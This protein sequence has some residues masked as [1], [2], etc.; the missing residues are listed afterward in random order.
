V[1]APVSMSPL[2]S[3]VI[4]NYKRREAFARSL[5]SVRGQ[6]YPNRE[7]IVVD[8]NSQDGI[9]EYLAAHAPEVRLIELAQN[10]GAAAGRNAGIAAARG[11]I[12]ITLDNDVFFESPFEIE[13]AVDTF[14]RRP[15]VHILACQVCDEQTGALRVR[16]WCHPRSW[17]EYGQTEFET[18][19]F[20]EGACAVR[21][22]VYDSVG[23]YYEPL[24]FGTEG[25][26]LSLRVLDKGFRILYEPRVRIRHSMAC[27]TR[28]PERPY[29][30]YTRNYIWI[31]YKDYP[32]FAGVSFLAVK[33]LMM[34]YF[35][36][37]SGHLKAYFR[38][39]KEG[40]AGLPRI[41]RVRTTIRPATVRY[42]R[43]LERGRPP[44]WTR[45]SRHR[46]AVQI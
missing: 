14:Q 19:Y 15:D 3:V 40:V 38:A 8:N 18:N 45:F 35:S 20:V 12:V 22:E 46:E 37:R 5:E 13:K 26:D 43:E 30:Y 29:Y 21:R 27:E 1:I 34:L 16:E 2:V 17:T 36:I 44:L 7:I 24:F 33:L 28:A 9:A 31:A 11:E 25:W 23:L 6:A 4:L 39:V 41:R 32:F 42:L 10:G